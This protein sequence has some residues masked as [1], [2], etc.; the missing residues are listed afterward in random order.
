MQLLWYKK[1]ILYCITISLI[2]CY[3][4]QIGR[5]TWVTF[6][7]HDLLHVIFLMFCTK[8]NK[9]SQKRRMYKCSLYGIT[10]L[11]SLLTLK[12]I[13][14]NYPSSRGWLNM[15]SV[16]KW[17]DHLYLHYA[18]L[19]ARMCPTNFWPT[20]SEYFVNIVTYTWQE[21]GLLLMLRVDGHSASLGFINTWADSCVLTHIAYQTDWCK[22][23]VTSC[24]VIYIQCLTTLILV[25]KVVC[26][27]W[28]RYNKTICV[29][30]W[31]LRREDSQ[32][33]Y[34]DTSFQ[35]N[36]SPCRTRF[37]WRRTMIYFE[38]RY[39]YQYYLIN[40]WNYLKFKVHSAWNYFPP[41]QEILF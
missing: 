33:L 40:H 28:I 23:E 11:V 21:I 41:K 22:M 37:T 34:S 38:V 12:H 35:L 36:F 20:N 4:W 27:R 5:G 7:Q 24:V 10:W 16:I 25:Y 3:T 17:H 9:V 13:T 6:Y 2:I 30:L 19:E 26:T 8:P 39:S 29:D 32:K 15:E 31:N 14:G 1:C 18:L